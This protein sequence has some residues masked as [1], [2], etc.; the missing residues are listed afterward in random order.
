[1]GSFFVFGCS[2]FCGARLALENP[3]RLLGSALRCEMDSFTPDDFQPLKPLQQYLQG[4]ELLEKLEALREQ[5]EERRGCFEFEGAAG[6]ARF[7]EALR[8]LQGRRERLEHWMALC[9]QQLDETLQWQANHAEAGRQHFERVARL[10]E[11]FRR[12]SVGGEQGFSPEE[13]RLWKVLKW[14]FERIK[15]AWRDRLPPESEG[16]GHWGS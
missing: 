10:M 6:D 3:S 2:L 4:L 15:E 5:L 7:E 1:M 13:Q 8:L 16:T 11:D 12:D 14:D 9:E